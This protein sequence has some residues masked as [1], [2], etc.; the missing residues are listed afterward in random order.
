[1]TNQATSF[2]PGF[3]PYCN[4][5]TFG[6][7]LGKWEVD[8]HGLHYYMA[9]VHEGSEVHLWCKSPLTQLLSRICYINSKFGRYASKTEIGRYGEYGTIYCVP[10]A[11]ENQVNIVSCWNEM[12]DKWSPRLQ[13]IALH[14]QVIIIIAQKKCFFVTLLF[15]FC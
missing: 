5:N 2:T 7:D 6:G 4:V 12:K 15:F 11:I 14:Q 13:T 3:N 10:V 8:T 1:V 9:S